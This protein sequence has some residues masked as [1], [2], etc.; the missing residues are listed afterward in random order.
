MVILLLGGISSSVAQLPLFPKTPSEDELETL[1]KRLKEST[2]PDLSKPL[3]L[4]KCID[5]ALKRSSKALISQLNILSSKLNLNDAKA[6]YLPQIHLNGSFLSSD[7]I[8]FGFEKENYELGLSAS[9]TIWDHGRREVEVAQS[10]ADVDAATSRRQ[11][12]L[13]QLIY[14]VTVAYY[15][16]LKAQRLVEV[17]EEILKIARQNT[18]K[19]R[20]LMEKGYKVESDVLAAEVR[21]ANDELKLVEDSNSLK[22]A[23]ANL[24]S[25]MGLDP[26]VEV[27][28]LDDTGYERFTVSGRLEPEE[29]T[30]EE[31]ERIALERRWELKEMKAQ[32]RGMEWGL[33]LAKLERYPQVSAEWGYDVN[34]EDY[35]RERERFSD[36]RSWRVVGRVSFPLFDGGI[37]RRREQRYR[38]R[39]AE[40]REELKGLERAIVMEVRRSYYDLMRSRKF[41]EILDK[42][43]RNAKLSLDATLERYDLQIVTELEV[44]EARSLYAQALTNRVHAYYDY[45]IA[46]AALRKAIGELR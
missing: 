11:A 38:L 15:N 22:V 12:E 43:V 20:V 4:S 31:A 5:I 36:Y 16:L 25:V 14:D 37:S 32:I 42:Q 10:R 26:G 28:V 24:A 46:Q 23:R 29:L 13:Q 6:R 30:L 17:D 33:Y 1:L 34:L 21:E 9:Y 45:K 19:T 44:A 35:L 8:E 7:Q 3:S 39:M 18:L 27:E 41:L 40:M 2:E